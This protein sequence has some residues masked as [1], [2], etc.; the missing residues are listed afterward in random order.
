LSQRFGILSGLLV[1]LDDAIVAWLNVTS[2]D[3]AG[4]YLGEHAHGGADLRLSPLSASNP[5]R[6][7]SRLNVRWGSAHV[8]AAL[9]DSR[10]GGGKRSGCR[11]PD[12]PRMPAMYRGYQIQ[13]VFSF[14]SGCSICWHLITN[15]HDPFD[16]LHCDDP[17][18]GITR[19]CCPGDELDYL[20]EGFLGADDFEFNRLG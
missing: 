7:S 17:I 4:D 13:R 15:L 5:A 11:G 20:V 10:G 12:L 9:R 6:I 18:P 16:I 19:P 2:G 8:I 1:V 14:V 3:V